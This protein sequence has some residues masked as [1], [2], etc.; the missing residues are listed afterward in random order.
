[1]S[2]DRFVTIKQISDP[3]EAEMLVDL[4]AQEGIPANTPGNAQAGYLGPLAATTFMVPL[5]VPAREA[6]RAR[7][8]LAALE[9][10]DEVVPGEAPLPAVSE[11]D[12]PYRGRVVSEDPPPRK[13]LTAV[14]AAVVLPMILGAFGAGHFYARRY[15]RG[16]AL[17][18]VAW[19]SIVLAISGVGA[20]VA[21]LPLVVAL[22]AWGAARA[23]D[24][25][26]R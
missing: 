3:V 12:G 7:A 10:Y 13:K 17:L 14:A 6:E 1:M 5:Q 26:Q 15:G 8:I 23:I 18:A 22:D 20:A 24:A 11:D 19:G 4:L 9:D 21:A 16:F 25:D 2:D